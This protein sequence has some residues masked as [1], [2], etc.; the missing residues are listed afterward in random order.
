[1]N[2]FLCRERNIGGIRWSRIQP[3]SLRDAISHRRPK[4]RLVEVL[5]RTPPSRRVGH[6]RRTGRVQ[7]KYILT[8]NNRILFYYTIVIAKETIY[9]GTGLLNDA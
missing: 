5:S 9:K 7:G 3:R 6:T 2:L 8:L 1:M 4:H